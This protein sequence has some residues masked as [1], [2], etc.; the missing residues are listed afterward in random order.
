MAG[1][2]DRIRLGAGS[3]AAPL[4][5]VGALPSIDTVVA[6]TTTPLYRKSVGDSKGDGIGKSDVGLAARQVKRTPDDMP[7]VGF[8]AVCGHVKIRPNLISAPCA[9]PC[10]PCSLSSSSA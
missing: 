5:T 2:L 4:G 6:A 10:L 9:A 3:A 1:G 8:S 7:I